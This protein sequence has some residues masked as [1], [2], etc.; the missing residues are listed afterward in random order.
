[1]QR[2]RPVSE[3]GYLQVPRPGRNVSQNVRPGPVRNEG[4]ARI[5]DL[6]CGA[7][8]RRTGLAVAD[9]TD[10]GR[11]R[12]RQQQNDGKSGYAHFSFAV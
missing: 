6:D 3:A 5:D 4:A 8:H 11:L 7:D 12:L 10:Y 1:M 2:A 9:R